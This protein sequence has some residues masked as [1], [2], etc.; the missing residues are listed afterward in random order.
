MFDIEDRMD[1]KAKFQFCAESD[2]VKKFFL[3]DIKAAQKEY[4][5]EHEGQLKA[6]GKFSIFENAVNEIS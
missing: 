1:D 4:Y 6:E 3:N 2:K 5:L